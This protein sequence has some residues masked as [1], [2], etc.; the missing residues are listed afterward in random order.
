MPGQSSEAELAERLFA[1]I[2]PGRL[3][4]NGKG[5]R[6]AAMTELPK[7]LVEEFS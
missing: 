2:I 1:C 5:Q 3:L 4:G 6:D 7:M